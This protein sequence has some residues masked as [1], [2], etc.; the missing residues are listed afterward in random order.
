MRKFAR[1]SA[2]TAVLFSLIGALFSAEPVVVNVVGN[3]PL[4]WDNGIFFGDGTPASLAALNGPTGVAALP[5]G[6][7]LI[8]DFMGDRIRGV[9]I[10][11]LITTKAGDG[12][13]GSQG[14]TTPQ[15]I[16]LWGPWSVAVRGSGIVFSD[17]YN[18][19]VRTIANNTITRTAGTIG[20]VVRGSSTFYTGWSGYEGDNGPAT[21]ARLNWPTGIC[22]DSAGNLY[23]ADSYNNRIRKV[24]WFGTITTVAGNGWAD[25]RGGGRFSGDGGPATSACLNRPM[26]VAVDGAGNLYIADTYNQRIRRVDSQTK[27]ITTVAGTGEAGDSGMGGP[28]TQARLNHPQGL[29]IGPDGTLYISDSLNHRVLAV[30]DGTIDVVAGCGIRGHGGDGY[31]ALYAQFNEPLG[32]AMTSAGDL[33]VADSG[34]NRVRMVLFGDTGQIHGTVRDART[35]EPIPGALVSWSGLQTSSDEFGV[36][37]LTLKAGSRQVTARGQAYGLATDTLNVVAEETTL[38][39]FLL[40]SGIVVGRV[41]DDAGHIVSGAT[42]TAPDASAVSGADGTFRIRLAP[43]AQTIAA[44]KFGYAPGATSVQVPVNGDTTVR[45]TVSRMRSVAV[46]LTY[47]RDWISWHD[48]P[49]DYTEPTNDYAFPAELLPDSLSVFSFPT[50]G[51]PVDFMFPDKS[52]GANNT[53]LLAGQVIS[54]PPGKYSTLYMLE[55]ARFGGYTGT[56]TLNYSDSSTSSADLTFSDWAW[57]AIGAQLGPN[58]TVAISCDHRH[59]T[60]TAQNGPPVDIL[61]S[62]MAVNSAKTLVSVTMPADTSGIGSKDGYLFAMSLNMIGSALGYGDVDGDGTVTLADASAALA[63]AAGLRTISPE[64]AVRGDL[65]PTWPDGSFGNGAIEVSDALAIL[66]RSISG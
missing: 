65:Q 42:I 5:D 50:S 22:T 14:G 44:S 62:Q 30:R 28:A 54:V 58:E 6:S 45:L 25:T 9:G 29:A 40:P 57:S 19:S 11:G 63:V 53:I 31:I 4:G 64:P 61:L 43:G 21:S 12:W 20:T 2:L 1:F 41:S 60:G 8:A 38:H 47:E 37:T 16:S 17:T 55:A 49:G 35:Y 13:P 52:D 39:D 10:D 7:I 27:F 34:N 59:R 32:L 26:A 33:V 56:V 48:N 3:G 51:A 15:S 18:A 36:Y 46:P 66:R 24:D 23:I